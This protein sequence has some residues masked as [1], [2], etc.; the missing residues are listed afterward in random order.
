[1]SLLNEKRWLYNRANKNKQLG[2]QTIH[3]CIVFS[4]RRPL[5]KRLWNSAVGFF[6]HI[7]TRTCVYIHI[8]LYMRGM[9]FKR[10]KVFPVYHCSCKCC[11]G[12]L[13]RYNT[14]VIECL[15]QLIVQQ[16]LCCA[17]IHARRAD[18]TGTLCSNWIQTSSIVCFDLRKVS[19]WKSER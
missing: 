1:M 7:Y 5:W 14:Y 11:C 3:P 4:M 13:H 17:R 16:S 10:G 15:Q 18:F 12:S 6:I 8:Y 9:L 19:G 2:L